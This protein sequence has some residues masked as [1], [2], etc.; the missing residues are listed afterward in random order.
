MN[1]P[2]NQ[3]SSF[4]NLGIA[5]SLFQVLERLKFVTPTP[6]QEKA[7]PVAIAGKDMIGVAQTGTGKTLAFGIPMIQR[8][9]IY[10][11][12]GL[13]VLPTR[14][15][16][17]Q[18]DEVLQKIGN[19]LG[20]RTA[21]LIGGAPMGRQLSDLRKN[22]HIIVATPGRLLDHV[23]QRTLKLQT[24]TIIV[25]DEADRM[26]DMGFA[27]QI[28]KILKD[29]P[30]ERQI[31]LF[32]ATMP[33]DI[34]R[35]G[36]Q[37]MKLPLQI[38]IARSGTVAEQVDQELFM[39]QKEDKL[40]LLETVLAAYRGSILIF[41]RTKHG[42]RKICRS[43]ASMGHTAAELH[44]NRSLSQR[45]E[46]LT[47]FKLG[48]YRVL[49]AT[50]IAARGIDVI[51]I[52][53]VINFDIPDD[54]E[55][56]VHRVGRTGRA[57]SVGKAITFVAPDQRAKVR[58]IERL[59]RKTLAVSQTP[60]LAPARATVHRAHPGQ[61]VPARGAGHRAHPAHAGHFAPRRRRRS[62]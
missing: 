24:M 47:G 61:F 38:E 30:R 39:V 19:A 9:A 48:K 59:T 36:T 57:G 32:S 23:E 4:N 34:V 6:I 10:K 37:H 27:P 26:L 14:E 52:E 5:P 25:L 21:V 46:A 8:L 56:Y 44:S 3:A 29:L 7:I 51:G 17:L 62:R 12:R 55:D 50:D 15:L 18:V 40:R 53:L 28:K 13:V 1:Q 45:K 60:Q 11:G 42:A 20:L 41:S 58:D 31:M 54:P 2:N 33:Q 49:V 16:A 35:I 43:V 22:P